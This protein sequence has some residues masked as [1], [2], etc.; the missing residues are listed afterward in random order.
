MRTVEQLYKESEEIKSFLSIEM[1]GDAQE[2]V[3]RGNTLC[4]Y[5]ASTAE[6]L[7]EAK[8]ILNEAKR[9]EAMEIVKKYFDD[10][11]LAASVQKA[12]A[13]G[14]CRKQQ[15]LVDL[16]DRQNAAITHQ[17]DWCRSLISKYK[18]ELRLSNIGNEF[19]R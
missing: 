8:F 18:E 9:S 5:L 4:A 17:L 10:K 15:Y 3:E 14:L 2:V 16:I 1:S 19:N 6:M 13:D 12:I 7:A 11:K